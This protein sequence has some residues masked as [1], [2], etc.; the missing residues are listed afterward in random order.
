LYFRIYGICEFRW[1]SEPV[2]LVHVLRVGNA[3]VHA[4]PFVHTRPDTGLFLGIGVILS[5]LCGYV[6]FVL[7]ICATGSSFI[8]NEVC[9]DAL[10]EY[11]G[12]GNLTTAFLFASFPVQH[13]RN[14]T[15]A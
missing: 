5:L 8:E 6:V 7:D 13:I 9:S 10:H 12:G 14:A 15:S 2:R 11:A 4:L 1:S 3:Q